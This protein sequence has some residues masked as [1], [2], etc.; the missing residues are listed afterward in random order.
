MASFDFYVVNHLSKHPTVDATIT[1]IGEGAT[2]GTLHFIKDGVALPANLGGP[3]PRIHFPVSQFNDV[4]TT[5]RY[6]KPLAF[7]FTAGNGIGTVGTAARE[8]VGEQ[9]GV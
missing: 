1:C 3:P 7:N 2:V 4:I 9:E 5:L 6:E 8:P